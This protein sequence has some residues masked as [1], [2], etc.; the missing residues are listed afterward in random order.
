MWEAFLSLKMWKNGQ[1]RFTTT[2][3]GIEIRR[4]SGKEKILGTAVSKKVML[5]HKVKSWKKVHLRTRFGLCSHLSL[6]F[7]TI[8]IDELIND[9]LLQT[10]SNRHA[11][12]RWPSKTYQQH[13]WA[14]TGCSQEDLTEAMHDWDEL[15]VR[16]M[17]ICFSRTTW[18]W[19][20]PPIYI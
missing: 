17:E 3:H 4:Q 12:I 11:S 5:G 14:N 7:K 18:W 19:Y 16:I 6:M 1:N 10:P 9:V 20:P 15:R 13:L 2:V 8:Q